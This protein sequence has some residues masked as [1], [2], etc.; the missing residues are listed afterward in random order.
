M[1]D[2]THPS[3]LHLA[4]HLP[5]VLNEWLRS[6]IEEAADLLRDSREHPSSGYELD[7]IT[8]HISTVMIDA[9]GHLV[10]KT[11][12]GELFLYRVVLQEL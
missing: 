3:R 10:V 5:P 7:A 2:I 1:T 8:R 4:E 9:A 6:G 11:F 12:G